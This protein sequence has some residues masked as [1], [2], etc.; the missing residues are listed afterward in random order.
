M[1]DKNT[2]KKISDKKIERRRALSVLVLPIGLSLGISFGMIF[3]SALGNTS[4]GLCGGI[5]SGAG[6]GL[7]VFSIAYS[8]L[9]KTDDKENN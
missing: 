1:P 4:L 2:S 9:K 7:M 6:F 8:N 3:G 5:M